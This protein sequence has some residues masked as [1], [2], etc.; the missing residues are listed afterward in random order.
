[1]KVLNIINGG[2]IIYTFCTLLIESI[3]YIMLIGKYFEI[4]RH[5]MTANTSKPAD[6]CKMACN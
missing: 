1:L 2:I 3:V 6:V 5:T 4:C